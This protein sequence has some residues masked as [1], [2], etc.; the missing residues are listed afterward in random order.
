ML[1]NPRYGLT[2]VFSGMQDLNKVLSKNLIASNDKKVHLNAQQNISS[3]D[4]VTYLVNS[5][6]SVS[7]S[8]YRPSKYFLTLY[9]DT[10]NEMGGTYFTV[11]EVVGGTGEYLSADT[12]V[13]DVNFPSDNFIT[14]FSIQ[15][16]QSWSILY[17]YVHEIDSQKY[18][19]RLDDDGNMI[20]TYAPTLVRSNSSGGISAYESSWWTLMTEFPIKAV[21]TMKGLTR[22]SVLMTYVKLNVWFHGGMK[23]L[24]SGLYVITKQEDRLDSSGYKTTL[25]LLRVGADS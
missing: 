13:L 9:D 22:P 5:M 18:S 16:D 17:E 19:Y 24:S 7:S 10:T 12:Y 2:K 11:T 20:T 25:T 23:H 14:Q 1:K 8:E 15:N 6:V 3:L 21:L 4:Y